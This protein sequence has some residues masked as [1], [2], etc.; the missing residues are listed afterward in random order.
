M[1]AAKKRILI[2]DDEED[3]L[4]ITDEGVI[5]RMAVRDIRFTE[6]RA[7]QGVRLMRLDDGTKIVAVARAEQEEDEE[8]AEDDGA[9]ADSLDM[10]GAEPAAE[11]PD[12][13]V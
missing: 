12:T 2:I 10:P 9:S 8:P 3:I 5:I 11:K 6:G 13:E 7:T 1:T 4:L